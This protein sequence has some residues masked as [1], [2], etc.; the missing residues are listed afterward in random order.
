MAWADIAVVQK[1]MV[2]SGMTALVTG[3]TKGIGFSSPSALCYFSFLICQ[4]L[5]YL[6]T[7]YICIHIYCA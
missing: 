7:N 5:L 4:A 3:G 6:W 1:K 2:N